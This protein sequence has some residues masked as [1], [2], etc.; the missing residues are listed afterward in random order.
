M[1]SIEFCRQVKASDPYAAEASHNEVGTSRN[2][3]ID[4]AEYSAPIFDDTEVERLREEQLGQS[5]HFA[6]MI[7]KK[8]AR[9]LL[10]YLVNLSQTRASSRVGYQSEQIATRSSLSE[11]GRHGTTMANLIGFR[12]QSVSRS[13]QTVATPAY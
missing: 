13:R 6:P 10:I 11:N 1:P 5:E 7:G 12:G 2:E 4:T 9:S 3:V 8:S